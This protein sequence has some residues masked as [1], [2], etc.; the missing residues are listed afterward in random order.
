MHRIF[1]SA[2]MVTA[3][4]SSVL[5]PNAV[6]Q[7]KA[8]RPANDP[9][10]AAIRRVF[11]Q[12]GETHEGYFRVNFPRTDLRVTIGNDQLA[13]GFELTSYLGFVPVGAREVLAVGEVIVRDDEVAAVLAEAGRQGIRTPA[14]HNHL[15]G[16]QPR[17]MFL[18]ISA[19]GNAEAVANQLK[20]V[21]A[22]TATPMTHHDEEAA[23]VSWSAI[24]AIL[25]P[26]ADAEGRLA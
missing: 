6:A 10:W 9:R 16:E 21:F 4:A 8:A 14:L 20:S 3:L 25:G 13:P 24:D 2:S 5:V 23:S 26:H 17:I 22:K 15:L 1:R 7:A 11:G 19:R 18:H 12:N